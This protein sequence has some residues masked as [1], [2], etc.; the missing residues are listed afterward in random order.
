M[1]KLIWSLNRFIVKI[2]YLKNVK[3]YIKGKVPKGAAILVANHDH[4]WDPPLITIT[5]K[6]K[7]HFFT[8]YV[9]FKNIMQGCF[10]RTFQ[11]IPV[12]SSLKSLNE[13]AF[14]NTSYYLKKGE[15]VGIFPHP[16]DL[17]KKKRMLYSGVI[18]LI[19]ENDVPII[20]VRVIVNEKRKSKSIYDV[21]FDKAYITIGKPIEGFRKRLKKGMSKKYY[22][23]LTKELMKNINNLKC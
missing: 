21:N 7:I 6:R 11:Q 13:E 4:A 20:P 5:I 15:I 3:I 8:A 10:L 23:N 1:R 14:S 16:Y 19:M 18:R 9:L 2:F 12:E 17:V 22:L